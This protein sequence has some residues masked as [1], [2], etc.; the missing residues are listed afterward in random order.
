MEYEY[1]AGNFIMEVSLIQYS[2]VYDE[3]TKKIAQFM[4]QR[5]PKAKIEVKV[6]RDDQM[7][8]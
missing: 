1:S 8:K 6:P 7:D 4:S 3:M 2:A 5:N